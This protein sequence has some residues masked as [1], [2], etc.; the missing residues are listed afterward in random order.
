MPRLV[1]LLSMVLVQPSWA[2]EIELINGDTLSGALIEQTDE[3]VVLLHP[4][5]GRVEIPVADIEPPAGPA[6]GVLGTSILEGFTKH[7]ELGFNGQQGN[8]E[9]TNLNVAL[10]LDAEDENRRWDFDAV[11]SFA[12]ADGI[13]TKNNALV[14]LSRDWLR[15]GSRWFQFAGARFDW[16][17]FRSW[18]YRVNANAGI[19]YALYET[20]RFHLR[21]R[22]GGS[23]TKEWGGRDD[24]LYEGLIGVDVGYALNEDHEIQLTNVV[25]PALNESR[26][27]NITNAHWRW[28]LTDDP[29]LSLRVGLEN[30]Y[31][32]APIPGN[33]RNDLRY[34][35]NLGIG[36]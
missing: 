35:T 34:F 32:S 25:Y 2:D 20:A 7:F 10:L 8:T 19:G 5:L 17:Q 6:P 26:Y 11:Y 3:H 12:D 28:T 22:L 33:E 36:F 18:D 16:D 30:E 15:P 1:L 21:G 13:T 23:L 14:R 4:V 31:D 24:L 27:R 9:T 29:K